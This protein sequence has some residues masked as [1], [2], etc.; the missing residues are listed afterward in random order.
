MVLYEIKIM[1]IERLYCTWRVSIL[2][3]QHNSERGIQDK[4]FHP[5]QRQQDRTMGP[6]PFEIR[7][8]H[9]REYGDML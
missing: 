1:Y 9:E 7:A 6:L 5:I 4:Y 8:S 2:S 3:Y